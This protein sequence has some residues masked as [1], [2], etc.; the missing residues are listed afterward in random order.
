MTNDF[1]K[2]VELY[3]R[4]QKSPLLFI[5]KI[6]KL[7]PQPLLPEYEQIAQDTPL[8]EWKA[9]WFGITAE[10]RKGT[11]VKGKHIT[12]HQYIFFLTFEMAIDKEVPRKIAIESG[13]GT[14]KS[15]SLAMLIIWFLFVH[16]DAQIPCTAPTSAQMYNALWKEIALWVG[17]MPQ[18]LQDL[19]EWSSEYLR[20]KERQETWYARARTASKDKPEALAGVHADYTLAVIDEASGVMDEV[21]EKGEGTLAGENAYVVMI[22]Q[23]TRLIGYFHDAFNRDKKNWVN[24][25][26]NSEDSPIVDE[27]FISR[28]LDKDGIDSDRYRV[29]VKGLPPKADAVDDKGYVPL[30]AE[31][32]LHDAPD[33]EFT[34]P[35]RLG[36]D[37]AGD[38]QDEAVWVLRDRFKAKIVA[39]E[40]TSTAK[41]IASKTINLAS[42]FRVRDEDIFVDSFGIGS[43]T[44]IE[45][46]QAGHRPT[47][48]NVGEE[49]Q[50]TERAKVDP[51][52]D[53]FTNLRAELHWAMRKWLI[54]GGGLINKK[55]FE[56]EALSLRY[57]RELNNKIKIMS[58]DEMRRQGIKSPNCF[59]AGTLV[60]TPNGNKDIQ[61]LHE[62]DYVVTP[63]GNR[64]VI[65]K[66]EN[67]VEE[68]Y[69]AK[70]SNG[71]SITGTG[72]HKVFTSKG[73]I[74]IDALMLSDIIECD[75]TLSILL[76]RLKRLCFIRDR[77]FGFYQ[78]NDIITETSTTERE[79]REENENYSIL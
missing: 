55:A 43:E 41:G 11:W 24:L 22:S 57:R 26:F 8:N 65:K 67:E 50:N 68:L 12:F 39:V 63:F 27:Q 20:I 73:F 37:P 70:L 33:D 78:L 74:A 23:H 60:L 71:V 51:M 62:G 17:R 53:Q 44:C 32:N 4:F 31:G 49:A 76:W 77:G 10:N 58:K 69:T 75:N 5:E 34:Y 56:R 19:Y 66:W 64:K 45:M 35:L 14:G 38:G 40:K 42:H 2:D 7:T 59:I 16:K 54:S 52:E 9:S 72:N 21:F 29:E 13:V 25:R 30:L 79:R 46:T 3:K 36:V 48:V 47:A 15:S 61:E 1:Q 28:I 6:W 18:E